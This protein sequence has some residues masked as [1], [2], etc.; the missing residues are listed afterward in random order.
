M[1]VD[2]FLSVIPLSDYVY[3]ITH[4][5]RMSIEKCKLF[6]INRKQQ[7]SLGRFKAKNKERL[8]TTKKGQVALRGLPPAVK[9]LR[10]CY[11]VRGTFNSV[12][13][14]GFYGDGERQVR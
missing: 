9:V 4:T 10:L 3:I 11:D 5:E 8:G 6:E 13:D 1:F 7:K 14:A 2:R 12:D